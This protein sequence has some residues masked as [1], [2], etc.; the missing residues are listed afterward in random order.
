[1]RI[2]ALSIYLPDNF[3][4]ET[5]EAIVTRSLGQLY[6][7]ARFPILFSTLNSKNT[8]I[9]LHALYVISFATSHC[10]D[11]KK[12]KRLWGGLLRTIELIN[13]LKTL[14]STYGI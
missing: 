1:M 12:L 8:W 11:C 2:C 7:K 14:L 10:S 5:I 6:A 3:N 13:M 9:T 4:T